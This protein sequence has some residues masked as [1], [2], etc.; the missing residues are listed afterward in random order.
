MRHVLKE[1]KHTPKKCSKCGGKMKEGASVS[2]L[3]T[4]YWVTNKSFVER[5][6][7]KGG[8]AGFSVPKPRQAIKSFSCLKCGFIDQYVVTK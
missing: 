7:Y 8:F 1:V 6:K 5:F 3:N 4:R 2:V